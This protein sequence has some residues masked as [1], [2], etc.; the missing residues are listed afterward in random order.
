M[1]GTPWDG[2]C[3]NHETLEEYENRKKNEKA[4][5]LIRLLEEAESH[6]MTVHAGVDD[7]DK[8][9]QDHVINLLN[10]VMAELKGGM[11]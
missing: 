8:N 4:S 6:I 1:C 3:V 10:D 7:H 9:D 5:Y 2:Y 11:E